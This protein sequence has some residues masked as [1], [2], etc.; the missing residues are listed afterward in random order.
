MLMC[1][2]S[3][4]PQAAYSTPV[5]AENVS[6]VSMERLKAQLLQKQTELTATIQ[7]FEEYKEVTK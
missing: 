6:T 3:T 7:S 2:C 4:A 1:D 5:T